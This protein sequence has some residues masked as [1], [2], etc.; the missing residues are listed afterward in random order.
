MAAYL[1]DQRMT[2]SCRRPP[3]G[4]LR[5]GQAFKPIGEMWFHRNTKT[6]SILFRPTLSD[7]TRASGF[8]G[9]RRLLVRTLL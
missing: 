4:R 6:V 5:S 7:A 3:I 2:R 9:G 1:A 8:F